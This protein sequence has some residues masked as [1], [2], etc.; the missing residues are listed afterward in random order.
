MRKYLYNEKG[1]S[2]PVILIIVIGSLILFASIYSFLTDNYYNVE[3]Y[4]G[5]VFNKHDEMHGKVRKYYIYVK[6]SEI[7]TRI[8]VSSSDYKRI[9]KGYTVEFF[10]YTKDEDKYST[11]YY[12]LGTEVSPETLIIIKENRGE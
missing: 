8:E 4:E 3:E 1:Y 10:S 12:E 11:L 7:E 5:T 6:N 9:E 2:Y